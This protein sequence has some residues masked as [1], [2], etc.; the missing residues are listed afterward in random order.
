MPEQRIKCL[1]KEHLKQSFG[2]HFHGIFFPFHFQSGVLTSLKSVLGGHI[3]GSFFL[4]HSASLCL[5]TGEFSPFIFK[6][7]L[8]VVCLLL[9]CYFLFC[10]SYVFLLLSSL[11]F[12]HFL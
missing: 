2:L 6:L 7:N 12:D 3:D 1:Y 10:N 8:V 9:F 11:G 5:L 4:M